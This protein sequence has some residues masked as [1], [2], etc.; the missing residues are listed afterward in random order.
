MTLAVILALNSNTTN[1]ASV[2]KSLNIFFS[3]IG[4]PI[5]MKLKRDVPWVKL[6]QKLLKELNSTH[7]SGCYGNKKG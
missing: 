1:Q 2:H 3:L 5:L 6:Y 4:G 7:N